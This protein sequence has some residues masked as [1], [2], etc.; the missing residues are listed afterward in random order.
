M[1]RKLVKLKKRKCGKEKTAQESIPKIL[2]HLALVRFYSPQPRLEDSMSVRDCVWGRFTPAKQYNMDQ[3]PLPF[4]FV[5]YHTF[6][7]DN[8]KDVKIKCPGE[9][10]RKR[11]YTMHAVINSGS[12]A[13]KQGWVYLVCKVKG[14]QIRQAEKDL[15]DKYVD[16]FWQM[17]AWVD[18]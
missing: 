10:Y 2:K 16:V 12:G 13:D 7:E 8:D 18:T 14:M 15:W 4:V 5:Q 17:N 1:V 11:Q 3:V 6:T 9:Q